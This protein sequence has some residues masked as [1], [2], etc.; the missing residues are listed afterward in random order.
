MSAPQKTKLAEELLRRFAAA[1]R[2]VQ[3]YASTHPLVA[4]SI[5]ALNEALALAHGSAASIAIGMVGEELVVGDIP[6]PR[7]AESMGK[8]VQQL[9]EAGIERIVI[10]RGVPESELTQ[11]VQT[12][13]ASN[14]REATTALARLRHIRVGR[15]QVEQRAE[16][17]VGDIAT[18]R[19]LYNDAVSIA[20]TLWDSA[21]TEGKPDADAGRAI[22]DTLAQEVSQN[23][24]A[25]LALTTLKNYDS[26]T[27]TH[28]V[29]VSILTMGQ[30]RGLGID[31]ALLREVGLSALMHDIGKVKTPVEILNKSEKLTDREFD[32]LRR[33]TVDGAEILRQTPEMP[34]LA[35]VVAF[36][37]HLRLDGTGY[38]SGVSRSTLNLGTMLCGVADVYD[39]MRSQRVYQQAFPTDRILAVLQRNDGTQFDQHLV[40]R[41]S[42]LVGIYPAGNLVR[43]DTRDVA[44]VLKTYAPDPYRPRVRILFDANGARV[45]RVAELN[46][47]EAAEGQPQSIEAPV[48]PAAYDIDPLTYL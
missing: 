21:K 38:P 37:H 7:A 16:A 18:Y 29:N 47:W 5:A 42:Q 3:L 30:A 28:M 27:F 2:A 32:I 14:P 31:G 26:Y 23:R 41:F 6:V 34:A 44:V 4:R 48:D 40:R 13:G 1:L 46:L 15:L 35:P 11:L 12:L 8:L 33:H 39:A 22:V 24:T 10:D 19:R 17:P 25:L 36:E 43:L 20:E 45:D 9:Q